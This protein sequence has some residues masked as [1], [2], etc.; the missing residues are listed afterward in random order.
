MRGWYFILVVIALGI[1]AGVFFT[2]SRE[3]FAPIVEPGGTEVT[4]GIRGTVT[5]GPQCPVVQAGVP[6]PDKPYNTTIE[7]FRLGSNNPLAIITSNAEGK[8][9]IPLAPGTYTVAPQGGTPYPLCDS[10]TVA[11]TEGTFTETVVL[12]DT[13]IR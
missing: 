8:F 3:V 10:T 6:C 11:V 1:L 12:C 9:E 7:I 2:K 5:L 4:S 13:G